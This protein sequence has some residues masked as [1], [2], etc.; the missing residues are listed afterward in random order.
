[1]SKR[2]E[3]L[4]LAA[5]AAWLYYVAGKTQNE[6]AEQLDVSRQVAQ[7]LVASAANQGLIKV[8]VH[9]E[10]TACLELADALRAR[11]GLEM[12]EVVPYDHD[13]GE[14]LQ[15]KFAVVGARVMERY[16]CQDAPQVVELGTGRTLKAIIDELPELSC[17]QHRLI[18]LVGTFAQ[19]GSSNRYDVAL[20]ASDKTQGKY[21]LLPAPLMADSAEDRKQWCNHRLYRIVENLSEQADV[22]FIGIG[23]IAPGCPLQEDGFLSEDELASLIAKNAVAEILGHTLDADGK[24]IDS[25]IQERVTSLLL[26]RPHHGPV[27]AFAG[28]NKKTTAILAALRGKWINGLV[29]DEYCARQILGLSN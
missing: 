28:G 20:R 19:D 2:Q 27:I 3:K 21:F 8:S 14:D 10:I 16:L 24:L 6:I 9:H 5:R 17:P 25:P 29:T 26:R 22:A 12:C 4:D 7:R 15:R 23:Y 18:S 11:F 1:M 13:S